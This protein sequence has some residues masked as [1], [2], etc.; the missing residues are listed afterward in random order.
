MSKGGAQN[1]G[2]WGVLYRIKGVV[3]S[4]G[5]ICAERGWREGWRGGGGGTE[6]KSKEVKE[7]KGV[8]V[9]RK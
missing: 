5:K 9:G 7:A 4:K 8:K 2:G 6:L 3:Q 1:E